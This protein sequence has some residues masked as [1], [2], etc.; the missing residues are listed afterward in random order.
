M[1]EHL[2]RFVGE[3]DEVVLPLRNLGFMLVIYRGEFDDIQPDRD[4]I[5]S[6]NSKQVFLLDGEELDP[7]VQSLRLIVH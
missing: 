3:S 7:F 2:W 4:I 5:D 1:T 6:D